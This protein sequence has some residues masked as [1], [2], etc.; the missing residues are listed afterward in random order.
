MGA[1]T[2]EAARQFDVKPVILHH[3]ASHLE[4]GMPEPQVA[5]PSRSSRSR[6][7]CLHRR[8][9]TPW[10]RPGCGNC[11]V[12]AGWYRSFG[13]GAAHA[14]QFVGTYARRSSRSA[15]CFDRHARPSRK[16]FARKTAIC[17]RGCSGRTFE[18]ETSEAH[19][20]RSR[21]STVFQLAAWASCANRLI[22]IRHHFLQFMTTM[23]EV[24]QVLRMKLS[25]VFSRLFFVWGQVD[26][27][28][29]FFGRRLY[30]FGTL[31]G[32]AGGLVNPA[33]L[34]CG[35]RSCF[36]GH[37]TILRIMF[38][39]DRPIPYWEVKRDKDR[40]GCSLHRTPGVEGDCDRSGNG[41]R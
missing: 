28:D 17:G 32:Y 26:L 9:R 11:T 34:L 1:G 13:P 15:T 16:R 33:A 41:M 31:I 23:L 29:Q 8:A 12:A 4:P 36:P 38:L 30:R 2:S 22:S 5:R 7:D 3:G 40:F 20:V 21:P 14:G 25:P 39:G 18:G 37:L 6:R 10:L 24:F 27:M 19:C 35:L